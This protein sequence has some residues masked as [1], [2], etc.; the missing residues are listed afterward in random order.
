MNHAF[1]PSTCLKLITD[2]VM[3]LLI[4][5]SSVQSYDGLTRD[6]NW[7]AERSSIRLTES[8]KPWPQIQNGLIIPSLHYKIDNHHLTFAASKLCKAK[9]SL[10]AFK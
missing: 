7:E 5:L 6:Q 10:H 9:N 4:C 8:I 2:P 3:S 1:A